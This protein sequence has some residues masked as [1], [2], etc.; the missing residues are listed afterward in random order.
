[1]SDTTINFEDRD[2]ALAAFAE[3]HDGFRDAYQPVPDDALTYVP[4]G[5]DYTLGG[6][7]VHVSDV[8]AHYALVLD[9]MVDVGFAQVRVVDPTD[10]REQTDALI[11]EGFSGIERPKVF[12]E[13]DAKHDGLAAKVAGLSTLEFSR[14]A[15]VLYGPDAAEP[16]E[17]SAADIM[18]W[19]I[20]HYREHIT[21][22]TQLLGDWRGA[23]ASGRG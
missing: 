18:G 6:L 9:R 3:A 12:A 2:T 10:G 11:R 23:Q 13:L 21:Q 19:L 16:Y 14:K 17:T 15:P 8:I 1:M 7:V 22:S 5:E 4:P 20:D